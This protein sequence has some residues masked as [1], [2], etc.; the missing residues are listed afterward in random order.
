MWRRP[1]V[2]A[3]GGI[4]LTFRRGIPES[5]EERASVPEMKCTGLVLGR[6]EFRVEEKKKKPSNRSPLNF[7]AYK[8]VLE[9]K[10]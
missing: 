7:A 4:L 1:A 9:E 5:E 2:A 3:F 8:L 10:T 6:E